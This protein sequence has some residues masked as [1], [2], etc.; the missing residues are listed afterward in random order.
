MIEIISEMTE[1]MTRGTEIKIE[2]TEIITGM[3]EGIQKD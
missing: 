1:I 2:L 3:I